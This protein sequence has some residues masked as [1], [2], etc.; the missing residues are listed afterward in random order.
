MISTEFKEML[1]SHLVTSLQLSLSY[2]MNFRS[3]SSVPSINCEHVVLSTFNPY[4]L[5]L[6]VPVRIHVCSTL[7]IFSTCEEDHHYPCGKSS[8]NTSEDVQYP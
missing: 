8:F 2:V 4:K 3:K 6:E 7:G 5:F 1:V